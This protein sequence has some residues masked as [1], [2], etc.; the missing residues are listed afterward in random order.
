M[1]KALEI[2]IPLTRK[3]GH[4]LFEGSSENEY[5]FSASELAQVHRDIGHA[6]A[7]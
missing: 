4:L 1:L 5:L 2:A 7:G 6:P 3:L